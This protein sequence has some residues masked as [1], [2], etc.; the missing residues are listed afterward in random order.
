GPRLDGRALARLL[1]GHVADAEVGGGE[2]T[3]PTRGAP[4]R[5]VTIIGP[6]D[7]RLPA[8]AEELGGLAGAERVAGC[9]IGGH[10]SPSADC[11]PIP[12]R[13]RSGCAP[14]PPKN[15]RE[16]PTGAGQRVA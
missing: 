7:D 1:R 6:L 13:V 4:R 3:V 8:D 16:R 12:G 9:A 10:A 5:D 15:G 14:V 11:G 2:P